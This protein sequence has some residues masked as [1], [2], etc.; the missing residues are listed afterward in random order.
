MYR[1][2][3]YNKSI[4]IFGLVPE[5][6]NPVMVNRLHK[7]EGNYRF[8]PETWH[9]H[10]Y[11][12]IF[13]FYYFFLFWKNNS[14]LPRQVWCL[15]RAWNGACNQGWWRL[16]TAPSMAPQ[17]C[18][19]PAPAMAPAT[20]AGN[21]AWI[22]WNGTSQWRRQWCLRLAPEKRRLQWRLQPS[23]APENSAGNGAFNGACN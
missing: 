18:L 14:R 19:Q 20:S 22:R 17:W 6:Y 13:I 23:M 16:K 7:L 5:T 2:K 12:F 11:F 9:C 15:K 4:K 3:S 21:G 1:F 10:C 8:W